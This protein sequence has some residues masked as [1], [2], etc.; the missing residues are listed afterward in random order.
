MIPKID[1][2]L[3]LP[4]G[5]VR[6]G[7]NRMAQQE[8]GLSRATIKALRHRRRV[9]TFAL[10]GIVLYDLDHVLAYSEGNG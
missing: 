1:L 5:D 3:R 10:P 7:T 2:I 9:T 8:S 6:V 4:G